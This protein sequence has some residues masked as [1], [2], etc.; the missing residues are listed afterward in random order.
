MALRTDL[1]TELLGEVEVVLAERVLRVEATTH[2]ARAAADA[3][4]ALWPLAAEVWVRD[5][6]P[7]RAEVHA[8]R[9]PAVLDVHVLAQLLEQLVG[10]VLERHVGGPQH[11]LG[12]VVVRRARGLPV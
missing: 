2:H 11:S 7:R 1:H 4:A 6:L 9:G 5:G 12:L 8:H 10:V 3:A